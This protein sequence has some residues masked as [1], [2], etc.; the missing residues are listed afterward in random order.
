M[1]YFYDAQGNLMFTHPM[2]EDYAMRDHMLRL[3][4]QYD[5]EAEALAEGATVE[6]L[7]ETTILIRKSVGEDNTSGPVFRSKSGR[8]T[9]EVIVPD[10]NIVLGSSMHEGNGDL[11]SRVKYMYDY[12]KEKDEWVPKQIYYEE[13]ATDE[14]TGSRYISRTTYYY[15]NYSLQTN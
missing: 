12:R 14:V 9:E 4:G 1:A 8:Y 13:Y 7:N 5:W 2:E 3:T 10:I 15:E 11:V 6:N